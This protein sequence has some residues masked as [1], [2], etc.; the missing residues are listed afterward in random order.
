MLWRNTERKRDGCARKHGYSQERRSWGT[1]TD[2]PLSS[3]GNEHGPISSGSRTPYTS[4]RS[5]LAPCACRWQPTWRTAC[6]GV[7]IGPFIG[8]PY[9]GPCGI[10]PI[11]SA[12]VLK[13]EIAAIARNEL[14]GAAE[15]REPCAL[16]VLPSKILCSCM[17][18]PCPPPPPTVLVCCVFS[19]FLSL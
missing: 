16:I 6:T 18:G 3:G 12:Q 13:R 15:P 8:V 19:F 7:F 14:S 2:G 17:W 1:G 5:V 4:R 11:H 10:D 9:H